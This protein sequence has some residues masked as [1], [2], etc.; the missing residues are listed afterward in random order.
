MA[1]TRLQQLAKTG[2]NPIEEREYQD[3]L[4]ASNVPFTVE[5]GVA[6]VQGFGIGGN[7]AGEAAATFFSPGAVQQRGFAQQ[8]Q[9][10][11]QD[12]LGRFKT[13]LSDA[14]TGIENELGLPQLRTNAQA[15][16]QTA[17]TVVDQV[18][19][20]A[21]TQQTVAKQVGISAPRLQ[22]R[23]GAKTAEM[24]PALDAATRAA[25]EANAAQ[26]FGETE[27]GRR[28]GQ[29]IQPFQ[30]EAAILS[31]SLAREFTGFSNQLQNELTTYLQKME[32]GHQLTM[33]ELDRA[34]QLARDEQE[35]ERQKKLISFNTDENIRQSNALKTG[36]GGGGVD[37]T[38]Y[39][40]PNTTGKSTALNTTAQTQKPN[41]ISLWDSSGTANRSASLSMK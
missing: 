12:F 6:N 33:A 16:G 1:D 29:V 25:E 14:I 39:L 35:F 5:N 22:Q 13:G 15:A 10:R 36:S 28:L 32:Q 27:F 19:A 21:P 26:Q 3:L 37:L 30:T 38:K 17:R 23:I 7:T 24:A 11:E 40:T 4:K 8:Q 2:R 9:A 34:N 31:E 18:R 41:L 20:V